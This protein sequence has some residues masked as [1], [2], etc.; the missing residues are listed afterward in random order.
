[1][2]KTIHTLLSISVI[3]LVLNLLWENVQAPLYEGYTGFVQHSPIC[4]V[5]SLGDVV[6]IVFLYAVFAA[7]MRD[8]LWFRR[9]NWKSTVSLIVIGAVIGVGIE[10]WGLADGRWNYTESMPIIPFLKVGLTPILQ[11]MIVPILT[12]YLSSKYKKVI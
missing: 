6:I 10:K 12:F 5:A 4:A 3:G 7:I 9:L 11:M 8:A 2:R 1:M